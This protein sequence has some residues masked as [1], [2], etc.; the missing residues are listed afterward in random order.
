MDDHTSLPADKFNDDT[1]DCSIAMDLIEYHEK[2]PRRIDKQI[3]VAGSYLSM[4]VN[5]GGPWR[6]V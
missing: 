2:Q 4:L 6:W 5:R 1:Q 3:F